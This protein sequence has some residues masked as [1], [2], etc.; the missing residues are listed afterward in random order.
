MVIGNKTFS[1]R[2]TEFENAP[3]P[4]VG[5]ILIDEPANFGNNALL[6]RQRAVIAQ[7]VARTWPVWFLTIN[8]VATHATL[9]T[10][11]PAATV[12]SKQHAN[13]FEEAA[14]RIDVARSRVAHL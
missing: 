13:G 4:S 12:F 5:L 9:A 8:N 10:A 3:H 2:L 6:L 7:A 14:F 1:Q 11:A